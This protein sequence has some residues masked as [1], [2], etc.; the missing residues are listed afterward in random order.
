MLVEMN[1]LNIFFAIFDIN[2]Y[3]DSENLSGYP[4]FMNMF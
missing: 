4:Q 1:F 3:N 2:I